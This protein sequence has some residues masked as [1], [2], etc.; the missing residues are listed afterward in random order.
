[1]L[2][3][4]SVMMCLACVYN[5]SSLKRP[6]LSGEVLRRN[7]VA[8]VRQGGALVLHEDFAGMGTAA[9]ALVQQYRAMCAECAVELAD[10]NW[11]SKLDS[12]FFCRCDS[13]T[14]PK[15]IELYSAFDLSPNSRQVLKSHSKARS[16]GYKFRVWRQEYTYQHVW[17]DIED[18]LT[19]YGRSLLDDTQQ[20]IL[21]LYYEEKRHALSNP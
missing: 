7:F 16:L 18:K 11:S 19:T 3:S 14:Q 6:V 9:L 1:M 12:I 4:F 10:C 8:L 17:G 21:N 2:E 15:T 20:R 13:G 5:S